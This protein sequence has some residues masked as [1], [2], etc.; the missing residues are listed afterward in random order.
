M[1]PELFLPTCVAVSNLVISI[2]K[3]DDFCVTGCLFGHILRE[4]AFMSLS[5]TIAPHL[6]FLRRYSRAV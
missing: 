3:D 4:T 6:P 1:P 2:A 5:A